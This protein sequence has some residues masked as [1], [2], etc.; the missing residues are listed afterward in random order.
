MKKA[1]ITFTC[2]LSM[3]ICFTACKKNRQPASENKL[4]G[5]WHEI[6]S[7]SGQSLSLN[8][9][10]D[11]S[12]SSSAVVAGTSMRYSGTYNLKG[13]AISVTAT[14]MSVQE[15]GKSARTIAVN[16]ELFPEATYSISNDTLTLTYQTYKAVWPNV[17]TTVRFRKLIMID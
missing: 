11:N 7:A 13:K 4:S 1:I 17:P 12:F 6:G 5:D 16:Q 14:E 9:S 15:P 8:F 10:K 2:L 3:V